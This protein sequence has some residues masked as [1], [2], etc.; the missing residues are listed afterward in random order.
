M[1]SPPLHPT[2][3]ALCLITS[4]CATP[5]QRAAAQESLLSYSGFTAQPVNTPERSAA[6]TSLPPN[7]ML[8][9]VHD[10][11]VRYVYADPLV[12]GCLYLGDQA[13]YGRYKQEVT[14]RQLAKEQ[15]EAEQLR[16][17]TWDERPP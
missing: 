8:Q 5:Q 9:E 2:I 6:L 13:A 4:A 10:G 12:C 15:A 17:N 14:K 3:L 1:R 16:Q 11:S 7:K